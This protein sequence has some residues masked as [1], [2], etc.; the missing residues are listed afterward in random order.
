MR[1]RAALTLASTDT[2]PHLPG[3]SYL[4]LYLARSVLDIF[5]CSPTDPFDG[6]EYMEAVFEPCWLPGSMHMRLVPFAVIF[7]LLYVL[8]YPAMVVYIVVKFKEVIRLD[9][10][11]RAR[12]TGNTRLTHTPVGYDVRKRFHKM[13]CT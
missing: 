11:L 9:Q 5:N 8:A 7:M 12:G 13:Y 1:S 4:Y 10:V 6:N 3:D 2:S